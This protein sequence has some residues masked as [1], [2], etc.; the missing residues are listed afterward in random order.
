[1]ASPRPPPVR[2][3]INGSHGPMP[4]KRCVAACLRRGYRTPHLE[5]PARCVG[6]LVDAEAGLGRGSRV[7]T[8]IAAAVSPSGSDENVVVLSGSP[9]L[10]SSVV[11]S[12]TA[13]LRGEGERRRNA[14]GCRVDLGSWPVCGMLAAV[15][16]TLVAESGAPFFFF[17]FKRGLM[18]HTGAGL[19]DCSRGC[20]S[21]RPTGEMSARR[22]IRY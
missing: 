7:A 22:I 4:G 6:A 13:A 9:F 18:G 5:R 3:A 14:I 12:D 10:F 20:G 11:R 1:M 21:A 2:A 19:C 15:R 8:S 16:P 17:L